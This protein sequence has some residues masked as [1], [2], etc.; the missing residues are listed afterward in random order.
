MKNIFSK[1]DIE[2]SAKVLKKEL[3][4]QRL[5][6]LTTAIAG[7]ATATSTA[8]AAV[9]GAIAPTGLSA[10]SVALGFSSAPFLVTAAPIIAGVAVTCAATAGAVRAYAWY[11][12]R[13]AEAADEASAESD[14][15]SVASLLDAGATE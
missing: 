11:Q 14:D 5:A 15:S 3:E 4:P 13:R 6:K 1:S 7:A 2:R 10:A 9:A 8:A 12:E